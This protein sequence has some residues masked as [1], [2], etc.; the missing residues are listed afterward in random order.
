MTQKAPEYTFEPFCKLLGYSESLK[1]FIKLQDKFLEFLDRFEN[2]TQFLDF[3]KCSGSSE[4]SQ[5]V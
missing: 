4:S 2:F 1:P 3:L 5:I